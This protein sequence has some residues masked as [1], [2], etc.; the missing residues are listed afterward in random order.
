MQQRWMSPFQ[1]KDPAGRFSVQQIHPRVHR[2]Q[3]QKVSLRQSEC[4]CSSYNNRA[5]QEGRTAMSWVLLSFLAKHKWCGQGRA[6]KNVFLLEVGAKVRF[7]L[8]WVS[9]SSLLYCLVRLFLKQKK[10]LIWKPF[11]RPVSRAGMQS[12]VQM[13]LTAITSSQTLLHSAEWVSA[14]T[15]NVSVV[16]S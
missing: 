8:F 16:G 11:Q 12:N 7:D 1:Q 4:T 14:F 6:R 13:P 2:N 3:Y 10:A 15:H 9:F 5:K